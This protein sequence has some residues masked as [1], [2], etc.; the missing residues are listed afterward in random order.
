MSEDEILKALVVKFIDIIKAFIGIFIAGVGTL[1]GF[2]IH[3]A[4]KL[5]KLEGKTGGN[6]NDTN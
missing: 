4:M 1:T 5:A 6:K 3:Q 2:V